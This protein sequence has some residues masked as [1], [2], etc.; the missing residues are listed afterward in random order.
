MYG[1]KSIPNANKDIH[2]SLKTLKKVTTNVEIASSNQLTSYANILRKRKIVQEEDEFNLRNIQ[3]RN[4]A[5]NKTRFK[6]KIFLESEEPKIR[7]PHRIRIQNICTEM[8]H[9]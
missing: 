4:I 7:K 8:P 1:S 2:L 6:C 5:L 9:P 3:L